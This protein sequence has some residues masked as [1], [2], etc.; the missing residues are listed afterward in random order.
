MDPWPVKTLALLIILMLIACVAP[1]ETDQEP[2]VI[3]ILNPT[4]SYV[5]EHSVLIQVHVSNNL[6]VAQ[7]EFWIDSVLVN[8]DKYL[9]WEYLW[10]TNVYEDGSQHSLVIK[11][12]DEAGNVIGTSNTMEILIELVNTAPTPSLSVTPLAGLLATIFYFD[13]SDCYDW[14][15]TSSTLQ[16]RW[17]WENDGVWDTEFDTS[18]TTSH[19]YAQER[20]YT[21]KLEV[22]DSEGAR[23][24]I[25]QRLTVHNENQIA[26]IDGNVYE[27]IQIGAQVW[28]AENLRVSHYRDGTEIPYLRYYSD[29]INTINGAYCYHLYSDNYGGAFGALYNWYAT[30][31]VH[32]IAPAGWHVPTDDEW[33]ELEMT[34]GMS[35]SDADGTL[36]YRGTNEGSK[37]AGNAALWTD[38]VLKDDSEFGS[39][40]F[41]ALPGGVR[42]IFDY[43][44]HIGRSVAFWSTTEQSSGVPLARLLYNESSGVLR[45]GGHAKNG[46]A[47]RCIKD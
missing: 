16:V 10:I 47:I 17:D 13:A 45:A 23:S 30:T 38:G 40:G 6:R 27:T 22:L 19:Q 43:Y 36:F 12:Y 32:N 21:A 7:L 25:T 31:D 9:P 11:A 4:E 39:S 28:M 34:L 18:K 41:N 26:D 1:Q 15:D 14:E 46:L 33:K 5:T 8:I 20:Q 29:W 24:T 3:T 44:S 35:Q 42:D 2:L 37:L